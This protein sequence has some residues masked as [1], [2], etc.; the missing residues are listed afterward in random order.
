MTVAPRCGAESACKIVPCY[1]P[2]D[3]FN[4][5]HDGFVM[6]RNH[7][8][9]TGLMSVPCGQCIGCRLERSRQWAVRCLHEAS[10]HDQNI[11]GT[12]TYDEPN[13]PKDGG[14]S[15]R[16]FQKFIKRLRKAVPRIRIFYCGEYGEETFRPH[17]HAIIFGW[18]PD[19]KTLHSQTDG[20]K[21]FTSE[22][23]T[24]IWS[25]GHAEFSDVTFDSCAYVARYCTKKVTGEAA[26]AAYETTSDETGEIISIEHPFNGMSL[27]PGIGIPWL[28]KW[29]HDVY[30]KYQIIV[31]GSAM[32]P[33]RAYDE[34]IQKHHPD[35]WEISRPIRHQ[36]IREAKE[37]YSDPE[38]FY[39]R[40][41]YAANKIQNQ[42]L[43]Q[44]KSQ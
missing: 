37:K 22:K 15:R 33:P 3:G 29:K 11:F 8:Q 17:Y 5:L 9:V 23:L 14:L 24:K 13:L 32:R 40:R 38:I 7:P 34:Y 28:E 2:L 30:S 21:S 20:L 41:N 26:A 27:K 42:K 36:M 39:S 19:D 1:F 25:H 18:E 10:N 6:D 31:R 35:L 4:T 43:Q 44:R 12:F 16:H